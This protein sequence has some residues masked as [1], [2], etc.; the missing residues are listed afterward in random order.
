MQGEKLPIGY[1]IKQV[2]NILTKGIDDI[3]TSFGMTRTDWQILNTLSQSETIDKIELTKI[4]SP[5]LGTDLIDDILTKLKERH[6]MYENDQKLIS[7]G[8]F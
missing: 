8:W 5:F 6:L 2:D 7:S 3:Q 1:W 4:M